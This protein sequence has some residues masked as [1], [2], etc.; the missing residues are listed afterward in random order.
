MFCYC[1]EKKVVFQDPIFSLYLL[2]AIDGTYYKGVDI[3]ECLST[4]YCVMEG[5]FEKWCLEGLKQQKES[6]TK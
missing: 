6:T 4:A 3:V 1:L 2:R 5:N